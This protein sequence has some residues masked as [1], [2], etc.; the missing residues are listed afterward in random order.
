MKNAPAYA[1]QLLVYSYILSLL[2]LD[3]LQH[4]IP[5]IKPVPHRR[6]T[7]NQ[8]RQ[9][10]NPMQ[11]T[12]LLVQ[13]LH[14]LRMWPSIIALLAIPR[15]LVLSLLHALRRRRSDHQHIRCSTNQS[16]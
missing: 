2:N 12:K 15:L 8:I 16:H 11:N 13:L 1:T 9:A 5:Q 4:T 3:T 10:A 6:Y 14:L 7:P